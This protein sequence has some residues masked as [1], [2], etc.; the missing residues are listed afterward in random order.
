MHPFRQQVFMRKGFSLMELLLVI[1]IISLVYYLGFEG[2]EKSTRKT[3]K[4]TPLT[5][6]K[7]VRNHTL[8]QGSGTL[9]CI[10][11][12]R[13]CYLR[14]DISTPF[15]EIE[16]TMALGDPKVYRINAQDDLYRPD[17]G[18]YQD[19]EICLIVDFYPNGSSTQLIL[20][21]DKGT[22]FLP[23]FFGKA[24]K[25]DSLDDAQKLWLAHTKELKDRGNFY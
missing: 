12:C 23:A 8:F 3:E 16:E 6:K 4:I 22:Y 5:L 14:K 15:E 24:Q 11:H 13:K 1:F 25:T 21:N 7:S 2:V 17:Y 18:R 19:N 10:D 9:L 20:Q